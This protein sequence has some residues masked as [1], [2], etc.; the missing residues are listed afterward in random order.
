MNKAIKVTLYSLFLTGSFL[1]GVYIPI[2]GEGIISIEGYRHAIALCGDESD[3]GMTPDK[4]T[5]WVNDDITYIINSGHE[6]DNEIKRL[7]RVSKVECEML[8]KYNQAL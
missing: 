6:N 4:A 2:W 5:V 7:V 3:S 8:K 1:A